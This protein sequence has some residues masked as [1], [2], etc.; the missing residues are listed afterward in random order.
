M[1]TGESF[2]VIGTVTN[3]TLDPWVD[4]EV[5]LQID[6]DGNG[7]FVGR[8][9]TAFNSKPTQAC[10]NCDAVYDYNFTW[11]SQYSAKTYATKVDFS[12]SAFYFTG[13]TSA[14]S[15]TGGYINVTVIGTTDFEMT[16]T[17]RL[18]RNSSTVIQAK[19][20]DNSGQPVRN[21]PV[22]YTWS[23][24][25]RT[26]V[27]YTDENGYFDVPFTI[28]STDALGNFTLDF[29]YPCLLYTSD[30]ADE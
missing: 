16:S 27:N 18:Y 28:N 6:V 8:L 12:N 1:N 21:A 14:L 24:D 29:E 10:S 25:G 20:E 15:P 3:R 5:A 4:D 26:G 9:E 19:L 30:A 2:R 22:N 11:L 23:F 7:V 13:N 17:P